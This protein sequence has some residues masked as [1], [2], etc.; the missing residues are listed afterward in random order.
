MPPKFSLQAVLDYR[1]KVVEMF[2]SEMAQ[3]LLAQQ[4]AH[5]F[6]EQLNQTLDQINEQIMASQEGDIDLFMASQLRANFK[7][8]TDYIAQQKI[9]LQDLA[10]KIQAKQAEIVKARQD[11][12]ALKK[13]SARE[14]ERFAEEQAMQEK[15]TQDDI[16]IARA[17]R[18]MVQFR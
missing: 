18:N 4:K 16:Y 15:R 6:L 9:F 8:V 11:E 1:H 5:A 2:E 17:Y 3:L 10:E 13:L 7:I 12:E 14:Q